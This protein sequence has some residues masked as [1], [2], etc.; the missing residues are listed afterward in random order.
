MLLGVP[1]ASLAVIRPDFHRPA[2]IYRESA[3]TEGADTREPDIW[4]SAIILPTRYAADATC[5]SVER[6]CATGRRSQAGNLGTAN[7]EGHSGSGATDP[8]RKRHSA[9]KPAS[10]EIRRYGGPDLHTGGFVQELT[11]TAA[12]IARFA[13][14]RTLATLRPLIAASESTASDANQTPARS[15]RGFRRPL[16]MLSFVCVPVPLMSCR[17]SISSL[18]AEGDETCAQLLSSWRR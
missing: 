17:E 14:R 1:I 3:R 13:E 15:K 8:E 9:L 7:F 6:R 18:F 11:A 4:R 12:E 10:A 5:A 16:A 2:T